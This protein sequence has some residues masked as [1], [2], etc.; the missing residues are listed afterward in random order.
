MRAGHRVFLLGATGRTG[1]RVLALLLESGAEVRVVVRSAERLPPRLRSA[2]GLEVL[3]A[4]VLALSKAELQAQVRDCDALISCLGHPVSLQGILGRPRDLVKEAV[5]R[6]WGAVEALAQPEPP[7]LILMSS[8]SVC[9]PG[10]LDEGRTRLERAFL[11]LVR[12]LLPPARD[13]QGAADFL[14]ARVGRDKAPLPWVVV[15]PDSLKEEDKPRYAVHEG[16]VDS[17]FRPGATSLSNVARFMADLV[18]DG[19]LRETWAGK[20][21]VVVNV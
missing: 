18:E 8:V 13:N 3:E 7:I 2:P 15:R 16:P 21:P 4:E 11:W 1:Q 5:R 17:L 19:A 6:L 9:R 10:G 12:G 20:L 14:A